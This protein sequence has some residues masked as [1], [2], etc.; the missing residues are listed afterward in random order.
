M[1]LHVRKQFIWLAAGLALAA[2]ACT[3]PQQQPAAEQPV[4]VQSRGT[5]YAVTP[6]YNAITIEHDA[7]PEYNMPPMTMEFT[8]DDA[9]KLEGIEVGDHV[10]FV[11][12]GG[13]DIQSINEVPAP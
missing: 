6:E 8:V 11:L 4:L 3:Q 1:E 10:E 2:T 9:S 7:I 13:L 5:V 12:S